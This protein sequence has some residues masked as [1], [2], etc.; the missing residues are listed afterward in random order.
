MVNRLP[1][2]AGEM[3]L[4]RLAHD[5]CIEIRGEKQHTEA[6]LTPAGLKAMRSPIESHPPACRAGA[7]GDEVSDRLLEAVLI[8][9]A[10]AIVTVVVRFLSGETDRLSRIFAIGLWA[11]SSAGA[12]AIM[13][14]A[15]R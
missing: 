10:F 1:I 12:V 7:E 8:C 11:I 3:T 6:R 15:P 2:P 13:R 14:K 9:V 5:G 4:S